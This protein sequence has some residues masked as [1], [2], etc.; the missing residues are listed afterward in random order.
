MRRVLCVMFVMLVAS[1]FCVQA[2]QWGTVDVAKP[3]VSVD[4][5]PVGIA[6]GLTIKQR[7]GMGLTVANVRKILVEKQA[8]G[9]LD[10]KTVE[11]LSVEVLGQL[12]AENPKAFADPKIDWDALIAF[13]E[14]LIPLIMKIIALFV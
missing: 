13:L 2:Q 11:E 5:K 4:T 10:G 3:V 1:V 12:V 6:D 14:K 7:R 8:A 9:E